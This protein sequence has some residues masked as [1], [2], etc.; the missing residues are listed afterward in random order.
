MAAG[1]GTGVVIA[2]GAATQIGKIS[3]LVGSVEELATPLLR[4]INRFGRR[5]TFI[6]IA[7]ALLLFRFAV[8]VRGFVWQEALIAVV[9]LAV[10]VV[11]EGLPAVITITLAIGVRRMPVVLEDRQEQM[12]RRPKGNLVFSL[13]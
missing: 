10:G 5:F 13:S 3:T 4:Q 1:Q 6:A 11:P 7:A 9:A 2:T 12:P 8:E